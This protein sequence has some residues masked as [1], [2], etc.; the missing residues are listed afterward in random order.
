MI[1]TLAYCD[2]GSGAGT[3]V[4]TLESR[5]SAISSAGAGTTIPIASSIDEVVEQDDNDYTDT[6]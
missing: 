5:R 3:R 6:R 1:L 2:A 4:S